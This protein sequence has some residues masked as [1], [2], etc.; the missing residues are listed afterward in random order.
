M[1]FSSALLFALVTTAVGADTTPPASWQVFSDPLP[2]LDADGPEM[3]VVPAGRFAMG[4][5]PSEP[6]RLADERLHE[7][8]VA[9]F[10]MSRTEVTFEDFMRFVRAR[11]ITMLPAPLETEMR[12]PAVRVA[13]RHARAYASW[14]SKATGARYRLPTEAEW[15]YAARAGEQAARPWGDNANIACRYANVHDLS[16]LRALGERDGVHACVDR[17]IR[18]SAVA[19]Y[20][21]NAFGLYDMLGNVWEWTCSAY[22]LD[23]DG[24]EGVCV[25]ARNPTGLLVVRGGSWQDE[26]RWVRSAVRLWVR[27]TDTDVNIGFRL[28]RELGDDERPP[29]LRELDPAEEDRRPDVSAPRKAA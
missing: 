16:A 26:P 14:L 7:V 5:P 12:H 13:L 2:A 24:A 9:R 28:V 19:R 1:R 29:N 15:E 8:A 11:R 6:E 27:A 17:S 18:A 4:S 25:E 3:V 22:S 10:A 20:R 23:Y 21:A